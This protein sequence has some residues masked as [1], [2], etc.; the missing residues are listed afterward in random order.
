MLGFRSIIAL[1]LAAAAIAGCRKVP[2]AEHPPATPPPNVIV[3]TADLQGEDTQLERVLAA[4]EWEP[5]GERA[6]DVWNAFASVDTRLAALKVEVAQRVGG[7]RAEAEIERIELQR[8]RDTQM[9]RFVRT[10]ERVKQARVAFNNLAASI[11]RREGIRAAASMVQRGINGE[12][13][14]LNHHGLRGIRG[15]LQIP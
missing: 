9:E 14:H 5:T 12:A 10:Q 4:Y 3:R 1:F 6:V 8:V 15:H 2:T 13:R 11:N 7:P